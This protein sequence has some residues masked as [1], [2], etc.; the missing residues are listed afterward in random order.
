MVNL[1]LDLRSKYSLLHAFD[2]VGR[3][4]FPK[5][6][7]GDEAW[8]KP[9]P[10]DLLDVQRQ[11]QEAEANLANVLK[12]I[13]QIKTEFDVSRTMVERDIFS[14]LLSK[15]YQEQAGHRE[16][17]ISLPNPNQGE[18]EDGERFARRA[19]AER[20]LNAAFCSGEL[21]VQFGRNCLVPWNDCAREDGLTI[22]YILSQVTLP[23]DKAPAGSHPAFIDRAQLD[24]WLGRMFELQEDGN[25]VLT[26]AELL[27]RW[28]EEQVRDLQPREKTKTAFKRE[29]MK[30]YPELTNRKFDHVWANTVPESWTKAG[31]R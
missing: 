27:R 9:A 22:N 17:I 24:D 4:Q 8:A 21:M 28:L 26:T 7:Q 19:A 2:E 16:V 5:D 25:A 29:A 15:L 3:A 23:A 13:L 18:I 31:R 1:R 10:T 20:H 14:S 6:W 11:R 30:K 12:K